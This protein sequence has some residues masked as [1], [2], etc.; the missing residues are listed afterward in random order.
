M[1]WSIE[2]EQIVDPEPDRDTERAVALH[3]REAHG[4]MCQVTVEFVHGAPT[5]TGRQAVAEYLDWDTP[6]RRLIVDREGR[7]RSAAD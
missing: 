3:L 2:Q 6:P 5:V 1:T 7:V 4:R